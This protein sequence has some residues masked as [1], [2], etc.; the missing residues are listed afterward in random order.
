[1]ANI[2]LKPKIEDVVL[3]DVVLEVS[4]GVMSLPN[5]A[6]NNKENHNENYVFSKLIDK[7][8]D[9]INQDLQAL[10]RYMG[11]SAETYPFTEIPEITEG[12]TLL[13]KERITYL[14]SF[15][16]D[17]KI[18]LA[19]EHITNVLW[20]CGDQ[21]FN[22]TFGISNDQFA[23]IAFV[24]ARNHDVTLKGY[25]VIGES[26]VDKTYRKLGEAFKTKNVSDYQNVLDTQYKHVTGNVYVSPVIV[27]KKQVIRSTTVSG[28]KGGPVQLPLACD[29]RKQGRRYD[30]IPMAAGKKS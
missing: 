25:H 3:E 29:W 1:M 9:E 22:N 5:D 16:E 8:K 17:Q 7:N 23:R 19:A 20:G 27:D 18:D 30:Y 10:S 15:Q 13:N 6:V 14:K 21:S 26:V 28:L 12:N 2:E 4:K 24:I 11:T